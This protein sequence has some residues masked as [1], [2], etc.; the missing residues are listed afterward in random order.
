MIYLLVTDL[1]GMRCKS[2]G[3]MFSGQLL[4]IIDCFL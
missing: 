2:Q 3:L 1:D 4:A